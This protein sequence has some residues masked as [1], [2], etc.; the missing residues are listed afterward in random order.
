MTAAIFIAVS[1]M[2]VV[3][4]PVA[5]ALGVVGLG[6]LFALEGAGAFFGV[7]M[8]AYESLHSFTLTAIPLFILMANIL[9]H[10][11]ISEDL[12][13]LIHKFVGH[14]PGGL[15]IATV[16]FCAGF[17]AISGSS[18]ATAATV[19][20]L[21]MPEMLQAGYDR[22]FTY[23][24]VAAGGTLGI[25]IPPSLSMI[26]YGAL[27]DV[28][29]GDLFIAGIIPGLLLTGLFVAYT[30]VHARNKGYIRNRPASWN[31]RR[32]ALRRASWGMILPPLVVGGIYLGWFTPTEAAGVGVVYSLAAS[33]LSGRLGVKDLMPVLLST[34]RT[35]AMVLTIIVGAI[36][37]GHVVTMLQVPQRMIDFLG[38]LGV[39]PWQFIVLVCL[40]FIFLGDFLEVVSITIITLPI[41]FPIL[42]ALKIDPV[43]FAVIMTINMEFALIT[44]PVGL[45]LFVIKGV[46][47]DASLFEV[48]RGTVPFMLL[49]LATLILV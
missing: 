15:G 26:L 46:A 7:P 17:S 41:I 36:I 14:L 48:F 2:L 44:P 37:F 39:P 34:L 1:L 31:E 27:T 38:E 4:M 43:W 8:I 20:M 5:F 45:N 47:D 30:V 13:R 25:L 33:L 40:V 24:L 12:Y 11:R 28:S 19:G 22:R 49:M 23:G 32:T 3:G 10:S 18:V 9:I 35:T 29:V 16:L 6:G 42:L 21:A